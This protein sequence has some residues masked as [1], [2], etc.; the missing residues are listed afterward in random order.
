MYTMT[1]SKDKFQMYYMNESLK[2]YAEKRNLD[3]EERTKKLRYGYGN[4]SFLK[5]G[6]GRGESQRSAGKRDYDA[7]ICFT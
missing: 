6:G 1:I 7:C 3:T 2:H 5:S 4:Q